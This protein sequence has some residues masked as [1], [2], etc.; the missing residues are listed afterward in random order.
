M[1]ASN[2]QIG[3]YDNWRA[4]IRDRLIGTN[5]YYK[6]IFDLV[7]KEKNAVT[8]GALVSISIPSLPNLNW[9]WVGSHIWTCV[10]KSMN[11]T[12][13]SRRLTITQGEDY[14]GSN[15]G[16]SYLSNIWGG[17]QMR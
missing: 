1:K 5:M 3:R 17:D 9:A 10:G 15:C 12:H 13:L 8:M 16:K 2:G 14:K 6:E 7:E 4:R 11:D